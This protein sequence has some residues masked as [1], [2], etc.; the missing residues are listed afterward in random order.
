MTTTTLHRWA[1][2]ACVALLATTPAWAVYKVVG[3]DGKVTYTDR[4]PN[5]AEGQATAADANG[6]AAGNAGLPYELRTLASRYPVTLYT[7]PDCA[8]CDAGR[9][10]LRQRG[11]PFQER[12]SDNSAQAL[13]AWQQRLGGNQAPALTIGSQVL[14]GFS[15]GSW[16]G[17]LDAAGYPRQSKLLPGYTPPAPQPLVPRAAP[18]TSAPAPAAPATPPPTPASGGFRF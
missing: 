6:A 9:Q 8:P 15:P 14:T 10:L 17:Y 5:A 13:Q 11:V 7:T 12:V 2:A 4:P 16:N 18:Q 1:G 3:P